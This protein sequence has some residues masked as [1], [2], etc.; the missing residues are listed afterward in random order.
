M[1][2]DKIF[3]PNLDGWR[4]IAFLGVFYHHSFSTQLT[5]ITENPLY[6]VVKSTTTNGDLGVDF[7]FVLSGFLI[8][9][10]LIAEKELTGRIDAINFYIRRVLRIFPLY[11]FCV[12]FGFLLFP[13][14]KSFFGALP[15]E[16]A[17]ISYYLFFLGNLDVVRNSALPDS[18]VLGVLWSVAIEEQFYL[19]IPIVLMIIPV[20][21]YK[22]VFA[23]VVILSWILRAQNI[24]SYYFLKFHTFA[25]MG[26]LAIGGLIAYYAGT[27]KKFIGLFE[28]LRKVYIKGIYAGAILIFLFRSSIFSFP[29]MK[30][31]EASIIAGFFALII[32]EQNYS[33]NSLFK[34]KDFKAFSWLGKY[35]YGL[36]C[37]HTIAALVT[38]QAMTMLRINTHL[39]QV[40]ILQTLLMFALSI[41]IAYISY[42][43]YEKPFLKLKNRFSFITK[44]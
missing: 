32:L 2:K 42:E 27:S 7:F 39:W 33:K 36:Y 40:L 43:Y 24:E 41:V 31:F 29:I 15:D 3:F 30:V 34:M 25:S 21:F 19:T 38:I 13:L 14:L 26:N 10:L 12:F 4:F 44:G 5:Y 8:I 20:R 28:N 17:H 22:W 11:F 9:Y 23:G 16:N 1:K 6:K 18:G 37:L 35:T